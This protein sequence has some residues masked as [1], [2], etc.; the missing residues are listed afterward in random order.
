MKYYP[1]ELPKMRRLGP[2]GEIPDFS[3]Q[4]TPMS[5]SWIFRSE[6]NPNEFDDFEYDDRTVHA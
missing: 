4:Y 5:K 1:E 6:V 3:S 2:N